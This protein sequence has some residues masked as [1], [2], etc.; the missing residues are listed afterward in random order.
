MGEPRGLSDCSLILHSLS[1][2]LNRLSCCS[3]LCRQRLLELPSGERRAMA[4]R[5][6]KRAKHFTRAAF[7]TRAGSLI[8]AAE[9][10]TLS[11]PNLTATS[12]DVKMAALRSPTSSSS[13]HAKVFARPHLPPCPRAGAL[14]ETACGG[15]LAWAC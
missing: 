11:H 1:H 14:L 15:D 12:D 3:P 7:L 5:A 2:F 8:Q 10:G 13:P 9:Q 4:A 6:R